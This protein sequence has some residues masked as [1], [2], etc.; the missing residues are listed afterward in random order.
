[1]VEDDHHVTKFSCVLHALKRS[2]SGTLCLPDEILR[3]GMLG[4]SRHRGRAFYLR[5]EFSDTSDRLCSA[6]ASR[7]AR[8]GNLADS[9]SWRWWAG[10]DEETWRPVDQCQISAKCPSSH[11]HSCEGRPLAAPCDHRSNSV[12]PVAQ[13]AQATLGVRAASSPE[14]LGESKLAPMQRHRRDTRYAAWRQISSPNSY[15]REES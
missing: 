13:S 6:V 10:T 14:Q 2:R 3:P 12:N 5:A 9:E 7:E 4:S 8:R 1:M 15:S 11:V